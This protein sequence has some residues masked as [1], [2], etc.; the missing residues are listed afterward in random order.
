M[1]CHM[2]HL[3][4]CQL[5]PHSSFI[6]CSKH[7]PFAVIWEV[8]I[9]VPL[10]LEDGTTEYEP[11]GSCLVKQAH[12]RDCMPSLTAMLNVPQKWTT[13]ISFFLNSTCHSG[14]MW[15]PHD[16]V[17]CCPFP[18]IESVTACPSRLVFWQQEGRE[19]HAVALMDCPYMA[20][21]SLAPPGNNQGLDE[22]N[23]LTILYRV[24]GESELRETSLPFRRK[25]QHKFSSDYYTW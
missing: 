3:S 12:M 10:N 5:S 19:F 11:M 24:E 1:T 17:L 9:R 25:G 18:I 6:A 13:C 23:Q 8:P 14:L 4:A 20:W 7:V 2:C 16:S 22:N 21:S 15:L